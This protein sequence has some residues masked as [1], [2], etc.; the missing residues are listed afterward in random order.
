MLGGCLA[1]LSVRVRVGLRQVIKL[2]EAIAP[3]VLWMDEIEK[4][5]SNNQ[6]DG[7]SGTSKRVFATLLTWMSE[8]TAPVFVVATAN[9]VELLPAEL[10]RKGRIDE[11]FF[12][13]GLPNQSEREQIFQVQL[14]KIARGSSERNAVSQRNDFDLG[15]VCDCDPKISLVLKLNK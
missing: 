7:D 14:G 15:I 4:S 13:C 8:K 3:C 5:F 11:L 2:A 6:S 9:Q 1:A 10:I 12:H